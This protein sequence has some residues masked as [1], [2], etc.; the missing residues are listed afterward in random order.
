MQSTSANTLIDTQRGLKFAKSPRWI[1]NKLV[2]LDIHDR[3]IKS[4]DMHGSVKTVRSLP[5]VPGGFGVLPNG[6]MIVGDSWRRRID[7]WDSSGPRQLADLSTV[8]GFCLSDGIVMMKPTVL[9]SALSLVA[10]AAFA[11][12]IANT[13]RLLCST[14]RIV[15]CFENGECIDADPW[16]LNIPQ[17]VVIDAKKMTM[18]T[19]K[20]SGEKRVTPIRTLKRDNGKLIAQGIEQ[21]RAF[22]FV[23][24]EAS[25]LLT[26]SVARDGLS[27]SLFGACTDTDI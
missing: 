3:C 25:G 11:D 24:D 2:F 22:G 1:G 10:S 5:Y 17:F 13:D 23:I 19:T 8:A 6:G 14:S 27:V 4:A 12:N 18:S 16:E 21:E 9:L 7:Q 15:V 26:A 20:A